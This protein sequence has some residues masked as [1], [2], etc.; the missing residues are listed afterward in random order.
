[1]IEA[2]PYEPLFEIKLYEPRNR[3]SEESVRL[4]SPCAL[5]CSTAVVYVNVL[6]I[7]FTLET[8]T[9]NQ[10][11]QLWTPPKRLAQIAV[12]GSVDSDRLTRVFNTR[13]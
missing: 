1:M 5:A 10:T 11:A 4:V 13:T 6:N 9:Y 3:S 7:A 12:L 2:G 8:P